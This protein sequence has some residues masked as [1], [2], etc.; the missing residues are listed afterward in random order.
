MNA[1][2]DRSQVGLTPD[3]QRTVNRLQNELRWFRESRDVGRFALAWAIA[4]HEPAGLS[5]GV[6]T[7]WS[8]ETFDPDY[9]IR[10]LVKTVYPNVIM[11][12]RLIEHLIDRGLALIDASLDAGDTDPMFY[13]QIQ[14]VGDP[15]L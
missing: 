15:P 6:S 14:D 10:R 12:V 4:K 13:L 7:T 9:D 1:I 8:L 2:G 11:R 5:E 3:G